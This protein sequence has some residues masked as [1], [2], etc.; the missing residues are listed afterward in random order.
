[1]IR[2]TLP[3]GSTAL[4]HTLEA[5]SKQLVSGDRINLRLKPTVTYRRTCALN[6]LDFFLK[7]V[8]PR[9]YHTSRARSIDGVDGY[10]VVHES[11]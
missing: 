6:R 10:Q 2:V 3:S 5:E 4:T 7:N 8:T 11:W 1:M 9:G